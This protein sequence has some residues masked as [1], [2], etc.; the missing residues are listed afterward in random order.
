M[1]EAAALLIGIPIAALWLLIGVAIACCATYHGAPKWYAGLIVVGWPVQLL[2]VIIID[3]LKGP[4]RT[5]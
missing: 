4:I 2:F 3:L 1:L 5:Y